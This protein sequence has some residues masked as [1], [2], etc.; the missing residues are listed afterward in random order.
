MV[1]KKCSKCGE[2]K[3]L[4]EFH[5][6]ANLPDGHNN[7]CKVCK[8][9]RARDRAATMRPI[10]AQWQR[11]YRRQNPRAIQAT[12]QRI[13]AKN[14]V[15]NRHRELPLTKRCPTCEETKPTSEFSR[16][17]GTHDGLASLC[18]KCLSQRHKKYWPAYY[19]ANRERVLDRGAKLRTRE[20]N[21][22]RTLM[23]RS[24]SRQSFDAL[25]SAQ[26]AK[27]A[28]CLRICREADEP[29]GHKQD[30]WH[31]DHD[32][33]SGATRGLLCLQCNAL[34]GFAK[35]DP[36]RLAAAIRYLARPPAMQILG[37]E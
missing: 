1:T 31:I 35:D 17:S 28:I 37:I 23:R 20:H 27:C 26:D 7:S 34:L 8:C 32:H 19:L 6:C 13:V 24:L 15:R 16:S 21:R 5:K 11:N 3:P 2:E 30:I 29:R 25:V 22:L 18:K 10:L 4:T 9:R 14:K 12:R 33:S 36:A